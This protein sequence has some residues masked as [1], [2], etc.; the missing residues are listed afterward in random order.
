MKSIITIEKE[1]F[2]N[3]EGVPCVK[4]T[5]KEDGVF[6]YEGTTEVARIAD[7]VLKIDI[8]ECWVDRMKNPDRPEPKRYSSPRVEKMIADKEVSSK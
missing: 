6:V 2:D 7:R 4:R 5:V 3:E 8:F 1:Y